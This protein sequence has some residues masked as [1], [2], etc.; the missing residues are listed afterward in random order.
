MLF[1]TKGVDYE[2]ERIDLSDGDF[3]D[4]DWLRKGEKRLMIL[5]HGLEGS[6]DRQYMM[7]PAKYFYE[8]GWDVLA[9]NCRGCSGEVNKALRTYQHGDV[10]DIGA[11]VSHVLESTSYK[12]IVLIGYSM[13]GNMVL[14]YLGTQGLNVNER[15]KGAVAFSVP[16][17]LEDSSREINKKENRFYEKRFL[18][19]LKKK[20]SLKIKDYPSLDVDWSKIKD[21]SDFNKYFTLPVFGYSSEEE[22]LKQARTDHLLPDIAVPTLIVNA[23]NDPMLSGRNYPFETA[24]K[25]NNVWLETPQFGGHVGFTLRWNCP[26]YMETRTE[27]FLNSLPSLP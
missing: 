24:E 20:I 19:K 6:S 7:R 26:T 9:W 1:R 13:G 27:E 16:C 3:L 25:S 14:K 8:R 11:V 23:Q 5:S 15:I 18:R 12:E 10:E 4:L 22:F 21:F 2:R 17:H